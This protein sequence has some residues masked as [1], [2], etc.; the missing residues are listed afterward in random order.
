M[1]DPI[2]APPVPPGTI[3]A[4]LPVPLR[5]TPL[6]TTSSLGEIVKQHNVDFGD[7]LL[8][9]DLTV[10][11]TVVVP[12]GSTVACVV[13]FKDTAGNFIRSMQQAYMDGSGNVRAVSQDA[14]IDT[15]REDLDFKFRIPYHVFPKRF[16]GKYQVQA[17]V[18]LIQRTAS[19]APILL[20]SRSTI[21]WVEG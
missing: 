8:A 12:A 1:P 16:E 11:A 3:P 13:F 19:G 17:L 18:R 2:P 5:P 6:P 21:F 10:P 14:V 4:P 9:V 20:A 15:G 7:G